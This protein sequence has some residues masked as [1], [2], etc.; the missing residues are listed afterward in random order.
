MC[1]CLYMY[2]CVYVVVYVFGWE[3][4]CVLVD[5]HTMAF[6]YIPINLVYSIQSILLFV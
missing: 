3:S 2:I 1:V 6:V 4:V 5:C